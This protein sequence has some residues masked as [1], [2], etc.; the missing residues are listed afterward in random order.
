MVT[1][2]Q[3]SRMQYCFI[4]VRKYK[5]CLFFQLAKMRYATVSEFRGKVM[6]GIREYYEKDGELRP[7]KKGNGQVFKI[8]LCMSKFM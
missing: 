8:Y 1:L 6:V 4:A 2:F 3:L 5:T 7:G